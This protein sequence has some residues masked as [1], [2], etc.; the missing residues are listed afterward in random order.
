[1]GLVHESW[2]QFPLLLVHLKHGPWRE[3]V[4]E[5]NPEGKG[6]ES[7]QFDFVV[8]PFSSLLTALL[9][10]VCLMA[11]AGNDLFS[12]LISD[13][14][15]YSGK[16]PLLPWLRY[17]LNKSHSHFSA[18][19]LSLTPYSL[20]FSCRGIRKMKDSLPTHVLNDKL[21]RFLQKCTEK[22]ESDRRYRDDLRYLR[23]WLQLV[24]C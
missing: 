23:V 3:R 16:D 17:A 24:T 20:P 21:P 8:P 1:M 2:A 10:S 9:H 5:I 6:K 11:M 15:S 14:K 18:S 22:F 12:S 4:Q 7:N 19:S 13:I